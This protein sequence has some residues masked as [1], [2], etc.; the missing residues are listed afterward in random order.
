MKNKYSPGFGKSNESDLFI[1]F[2]NLSRSYSSLGTV[3]EFPQKEVENDEEYNR[4]ETFFAG[5]QSNWDI[6]NIEAFSLGGD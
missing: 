2:K 5:S 1:S 3:Y 4:P 6:V